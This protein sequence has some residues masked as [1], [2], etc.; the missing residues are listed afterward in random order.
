MSKLKLGIIMIDEPFY[1][2]DFINQLLNN[3]EIKYVL[4]HT[5]FVSVER[6]IKTLMIDFYTHIINLKISIF[7]YSINISLIFILGKE[8]K[9]Y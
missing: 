7:I 3:F 6:I 2:K 4:L 9:T 8:N 1:S 5:E